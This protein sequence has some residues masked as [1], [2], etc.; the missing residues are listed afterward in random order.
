LKAPD[1]RNL[2]DKS[3]EKRL[4][5][6]VYLAHAGLASRRAAETLITSGRVSVNGT[7]ISVLGEKVSMND[8][9]RLDGIPVKP[10]TRF[11]YLALNKPSGY[12]CSSQDPQGRPLA[13]DLL[14]NNIKERLYSV[15]RLDFQS[16]GLI[17]FTYDG[18]FAAKVSHPSRGIEKEYILETSG[19]IPDVVLET[20]INGI[21]IEGI[22]Y[23]ALH[24][25]R[26][27]KK[28]LKIIL[29][30]GK[31]REIRRVFSH[32]HLHILKLRRIR[33]GTIYLGDL[34]EGESRALSPQEIQDLAGNDFK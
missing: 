21:A 9:I 4:R 19:K 29:I 3:E 28:Q 26:L 24:I 7:V 16:S 1:I 34:K 33:I 11:L 2:P 18:N 25:E 17:I 13:L 22:H 14:P 31:N 6:Q 8:E 12:I 20:F 15:G 5:L 23:K 32:F 27:G 10:E 30:E